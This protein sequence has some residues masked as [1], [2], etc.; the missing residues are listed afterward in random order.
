MKTIKFLALMAIS[1]FSLSSF[2]DYYRGETVAHTVSRDADKMQ[3]S[4]SASFT[5]KAPI[6]EVYN[7]YELQLVSTPILNCTTE[8]GDGSN[9][10]WYGSFY[11][12]KAERAEGLA[13]AIKGV[14]EATAPLLVPFLK[15]RPR[16][17]AEFS[18]AIKL[19]DEV[20]KKGIAY[21]VLTQYGRENMQNLGYLDAETDCEVILVQELQLVEVEKQRLVKYVQ[22]SFNLLIQNAPLLKG[23]SESFKV[24]FDGL[25][26]KV[27]TYSNYNNY[28]VFMDEGSR[29]TDIVLEG[30]RRIVRPNNTL[31]VDFSFENGIA[32]LKVTDKLFD[33]SFPLDS[34]VQVSLMQ[35]GKGWGK[36]ETYSRTFELSKTSPTTVIK[37]DEASFAK[38]EKYSIEYRLKRQAPEFFTSDLSS[39]QN[40]YK[41]KY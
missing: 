41:L 17:W 6:Y 29:E 10:Q 9:G 34:L 8:G 22:K 31:D 23:E 40:T 18:E 11:G 16:S 38:G 24:T 12:S 33:A 37:L 26:T 3:K 39:A 14:G 32:V 21:R 35:K 20:H 27:F 5:L 25:E 30:E 2:A 19:A 28:E 13:Q 36:T 7:T 1:L 15:S 4:G